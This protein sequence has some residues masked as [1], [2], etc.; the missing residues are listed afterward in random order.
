M[1]PEIDLLAPDLY[2]GDPYPTYAWMRANEPVYWDA[3]NEL[4]GIARYDDIVPDREGQGDLHQLGHEQGWL[5]ARTSRPTRRSSGSTTRCTT[6]AAT[7]CPAGSR[8]ER[9]VPGRTTSGTGSPVCSSRRR[10]AAGR[11]RS[12]SELAAPLPAMMIGKLLGFDEDEWPKLKY[13]SETTIASA[14]GRATST[15]SGWISAM[16]FAQ[17]CADL[18]AAKRSA[19]GRRRHEPLHDGGDRRLPDGRGDRH[20]RLAAAARRRRRDDPYR[21]RPHHPQPLRATR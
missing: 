15:R 14:A 12:S 11:P 6:S 1:R 16:E 4:W 10:Q 7:W 17:A 3:A 13:W 21:H 5:P 9:R 19:P 8:P 18:F 2:A 20:R